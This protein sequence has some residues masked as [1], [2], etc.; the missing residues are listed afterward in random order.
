MRAG[1]LIALLSG[2][3]ALSPVVA[4]SSFG[5]WYAGASDDK[6]KHFAI[7]LNDSGNMLGEYCYPK[8]GGNCYWMFAV[9]AACVKGDKYPVLV[10]AES[11]ALYL[12]IYCYEPAQTGLSQFAFTDFDRSNN[13]I[14]KN[15]RIGIAMPMQGD[16]FRVVRFDLN[17]ATAA[18][19]AMLKNANA[20][21]NASTHDQTL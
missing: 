17:G 18:L 10:N 14:A 5:S 7:T 1:I 9:S 12:E 15:S 11:G 19:G 20:V 6:A 21:L 16:Q 8:S 2:S 13:I 3:T 4:Q